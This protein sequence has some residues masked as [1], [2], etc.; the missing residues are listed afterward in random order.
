MSDLLLYVHSEYIQN[1]TEADALAR[2]QKDLDE[3]KF[4]LVRWS[5]ILHWQ[6]QSDIV[7]LPFIFGTCFSFLLSFMAAS[8]D[9]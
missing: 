4:V 2:V 9:G 7:Y 5:L 6:A 8:S 1:P 3:T